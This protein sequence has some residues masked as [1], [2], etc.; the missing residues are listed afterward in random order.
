VRER[1]K[2]RERV[3]LC[4]CA[5]VCEKE[6]ARERECVCV[7]LSLSPSRCRSAH[8]LVRV[9]VCACACACIDMC[10]HVCVRACVYLKKDAM[11][12]TT[13]MGSWLLSSTV[14]EPVPSADLYTRSPSKSISASSHI[15]AVNMGTDTPPGITA[16][17]YVWVWGCV[18]R[19]SES[20]SERVRVCARETERDKVCV[21]ESV[22]A[23]LSCQQWALTLL[24]I[25][26]CILMC[27]CAFERERE[28]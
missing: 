14:M 1:E 17:V 6:R 24:G 28:R 13:A 3:C 9:C 25:T 2:E 16:C 10:V 4:A 27:L 20:E 22:I 19:E 12:A 18:R 23:H 15:S 7:S 26:A 5:C 11:R 21:C 8:V